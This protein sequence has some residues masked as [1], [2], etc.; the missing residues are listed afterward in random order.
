MDSGT[1]VLSLIPSHHDH[2]IN[3]KIGIQLEFDHLV[4]FPK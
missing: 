1:E 3:E 4:I 2:Q